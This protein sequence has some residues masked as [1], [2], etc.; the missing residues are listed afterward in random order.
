MRAS[1]IIRMSSGDP[2]SWLAIKPGWK[3][4][5]A[6]GSEIGEVNEVTGDERTDIFD[7]LSVAVSALGQP[8]YV[9]AEQV[10]GIEQGA[11]RLSLDHEQA[12]QLARFLEPATSAQIEPDDHGGLAERL[13]ADVRE[14]EG[15]VIEP[16]QRHE[17]PLNI[18]TRL[19]HLLRRLRS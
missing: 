11:V 4:L 6:D 19:A 2:V 10:A 12:A 17:H 18:W 15:K 3:V 14:V 5:T 9:T 8:R 13:A 16:T 7:G 1:M